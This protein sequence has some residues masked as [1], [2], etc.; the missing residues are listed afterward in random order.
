MSLSIR[1]AAKPWFNKTKNF[2]LTF[3]AVAT[4][5]SC[6]KSCKGGAQQEQRED[7]ELM[8]ADTTIV[9]A[10]DMQKMNQ[11][12][13]ASK[14]KE[15]QQQDPNTLKTYQDFIKKCGVN[16]EQQV[17]TLTL[18]LP[19]SIEKD[20][21]EALGIV[22]GKMT[23]KDVLACIDAYKEKGLERTSSTFNGYTIHE[24]PSKKIAFVLPT[25][26]ELVLFGKKSRVEQALLVRDKKANSVKTN[27]AFVTLVERA[28]GKD[29]SMWAAWAIS[30]EQSVKFKTVLERA[31]GTP[32]SMKNLTFSLV[33]KE[34]AQMNLQIDAANADEVKKGVESLNQKLEEIKKNP[35][36]QM[37]GFTGFL[38]LIK[39]EAKNETMT[40]NVIVSQA[41]TD[42]LITRL[43][44]LSKSI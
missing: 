30:A 42:D 17:G 8:P 22:R 31:L 11:S 5:A 20:S 36:V 26:K 23:E 21:S 38:S 9:F 33:L 24:I 28:S 29:A 19:S 40:M 41:Q 35:Q 10:V 2:V 4:L 39:I 16:P 14:A 34:N 15:L 12:H 13:L 37:L 3:A 43:M 32:V 7:L 44:G 18:A 25:G 6:T 27:Q 1:F